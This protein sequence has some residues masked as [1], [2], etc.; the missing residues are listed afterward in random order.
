M[1]TSERKNFKVHIRTEPDRKHDAYFVKAKD[2]KQARE[3]VASMPDVFC[4]TRVE[5]G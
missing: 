3:I 2:A 4:V 1:K 5:S